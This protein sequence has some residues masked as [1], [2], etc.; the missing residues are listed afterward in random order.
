MKEF[1][2]TFSFGC[3]LTSI[4]VHRKVFI[5]LGGPADA[6]SRKQWKQPVD[7]TLL[8]FPTDP[9]LH[10]FARVADVVPRLG[11]TRIVPVSPTRAC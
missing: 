9:F 6:I 4:Q 10:H 2:D 8:L 7:I 3:H 5:D 11:E 1:L